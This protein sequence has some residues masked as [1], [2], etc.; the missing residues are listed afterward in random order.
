MITSIRYMYLSCVPDGSTTFLFVGLYCVTVRY[1]TAETGNSE[2][3]VLEMLD[4]DN[5]H[6]YQ[7]R[8]SLFATFHGENV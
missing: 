4:S 2:R 5:Q 8:R 1:Y 3:C 7:S 6:N